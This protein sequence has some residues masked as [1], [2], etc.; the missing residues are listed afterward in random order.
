MTLEVVNN[1][2][3]NAIKYSPVGSEIDIE[4]TQQEEWC[5]LAVRDRG[6]GI[7][8]SDREVIF[9]RFRQGR[10]DSTGSQQ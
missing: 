4:L 2:I 9:E 10:H 1:L 7:H 8:E 6:P 3:D 5:K